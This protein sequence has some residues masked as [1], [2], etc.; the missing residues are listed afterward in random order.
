MEMTLVKSVHSLKRENFFT[1]LFSSNGEAQRKDGCSG[2][3][4]DSRGSQS[5]PGTDNKNRFIRQ[6]LAERNMDD[7][8][9]LQ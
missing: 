7:Y 5:E 4:A 2:T 1:F 3:V 9:H 6:V 8:R